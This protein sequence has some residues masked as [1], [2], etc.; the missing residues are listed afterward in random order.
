MVIYLPP[1][2]L[3]VV[4]HEQILEIAG[5]RS[6]ILDHNKI[7]AAVH[8]P[9]T[10]ISYSSECDIHTVCAVLMD[11]L[12]RNHAFA[13]GNKRTGLMTALVTY[14]LNGYTIKPSADNVEL[15]ELV[16]WVVNSKPPI[17]DIAAKLRV[18]I[19]K[20]S[21]KKLNQH[22]KSFRKLFTPYNSQLD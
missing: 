14:E 20:Y 13:D 3:V 5:G 4:L 8:R 12:A 16:L 19:N 15:E 11:S 21:T 17:D 9:K 18:L 10:F 7:E 1:A 22:M 2:E 6:G